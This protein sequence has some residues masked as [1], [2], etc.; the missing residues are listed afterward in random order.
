[1]SLGDVAALVAS[2]VVFPALSLFSP[3]GAD[4]E[5]RDLRVHSNPLGQKILYRP[6][7]LDKMVLWEQWGMKEYDGLTIREGD[8]VIDIGGH[9]GTSALNYAHHVGPRG[10]VYSIEALPEN[11]RILSKNIQANRIDNVRPFNMAIVGDP[12]LDRIELNTNPYNSGGHSVLKLSVQEQA[13]VVC[14]AMTLDKFIEAQGINRIDILQMDVEGAEF[15]IFLN[16]D[17]AL[18]S[19]IPQIIFEYHDAFASGHEHAELL[20]L[21][22]DL[23]FKTR[24]SRNM[25]SRA[26]NLDTGVVYACK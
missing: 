5:D 7:T 15:D 3:R 25:I 6:N 8:V 14:P 16:A 23:G 2:K 11:F 1:M 26:L 22:R 24:V 17:K 10:M 18:L 20:E 21:L 12:N 4:E 19:S 9:I 13:T